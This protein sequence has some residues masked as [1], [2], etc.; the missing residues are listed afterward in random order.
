MCIHAAHTWHVWQVVGA[1]AMRILLLVSPLLPS[2][3][4]GTWEVA[5]QG[6]KLGVGGGTGKEQLSCGFGTGGRAHRLHT[7]RI[8]PGMEATCSGW[9]GI[10]SWGG[11][12][13]VHAAC[14]AGACGWQYPQRLWV[15]G[16]NHGEGCQSPPHCPYVAPEAR[17][18]EPS[19]LQC[20]VWN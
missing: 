7:A 4:P 3:V 8:W 12:W 18:R 6:R 13:Q 15:I 9:I 1:P 16:Y 2:T 20:V 11:R 17:R 10:S 5:D 14:S 19:S